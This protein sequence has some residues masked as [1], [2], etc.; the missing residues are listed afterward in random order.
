MPFPVFSRYVNIITI[1]NE[2]D[3]IIQEIYNIG[4]PEEEYEK[5]INRQWI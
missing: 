4:L 3:P 1:K 2:D 5:K